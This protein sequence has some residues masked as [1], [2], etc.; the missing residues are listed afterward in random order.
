MQEERQ[1]TLDLT[2]T[3]ANIV[4]DALQ[5]EGARLRER[6]EPQEMLPTCDPMRWQHR[7]NV[8]GRLQLNIEEALR[9]E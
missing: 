3:E 5:R 7:M 4:W 6:Y 9:K 1:I 8:V 2:E